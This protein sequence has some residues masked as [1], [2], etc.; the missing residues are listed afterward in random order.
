MVFSSYFLKINMYYNG[1]NLEITYRIFPV[2]QPNDA[3]SRSYT[4]F[5]FVNCLLPCS[6]TYVKHMSALGI[7]G[8]GS[9]FDSLNSIS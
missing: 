6:K 8:V 5:I 2:E 7:K 9:S 4:S 3:H 1:Y